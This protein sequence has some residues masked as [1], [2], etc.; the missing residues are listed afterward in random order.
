M[1]LTNSESCRSADTPCG[2]DRGSAYARRLLQLWPSQH[3]ALC[4]P[5][6]YVEHSQRPDSCP[7]AELR[8][9]WPQ[10]WFSSSFHDWLRDRSSLLQAEESVTSMRWPITPAFGSCRRRFQPFLLA[11]AFA[12][13]SS[14]SA[15]NPECCDNKSALL[16]G[17]WQAA[18][19]G[20]ASSMERPA[21]NDV[22]ARRKK[23]WQAMEFSKSLTQTSIRMF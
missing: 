18:R 10:Q 23:I 1:S 2:C 12:T 22:T 6:G 21:T 5:G 19:P 3:I 11:G 8:T 17:T 16:W 20:N 14:P 9:Q 13:Y 15:S 7:L 4:R